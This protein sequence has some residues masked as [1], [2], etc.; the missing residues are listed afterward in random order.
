MSWKTGLAVALVAAAA[1]IAIVAI[2]GNDDSA[3]A[4]E[5]DGAFITQM[6][7]HHESAIE[8]AEMARERA[9]HPEVKDLA[10][11]IIDTQSNEI[12]K[13]GGH[14]ERLFGEPMD[15]A[16]HGTLGLAAHESGM[17]ADMSALEK[18]KPFDRAFI[19]AMVPHHQGAI[20]MARIELA[21]G[22]DA[23]LQALASAIIEAQ[24]REIVAMNQWR[25]DW[26][27]A[28]S[29]AGGIPPDE[30]EEGPSHDAMDH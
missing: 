5:T 29:P 30:G 24:S 23:E 25:V 8:M 10:A 13:L 4:K 15:S 21:R 17:D 12:G 1:V 26:Y 3:D 20:R 11:A 9:Q 19:D 28:P 27:G 7:P 22:E 14:H 2:V 6:A 18:A 16:D